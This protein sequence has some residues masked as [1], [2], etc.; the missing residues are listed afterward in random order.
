[1]LKIEGSVE[2]L[3]LIKQL[4]NNYNTK[5]INLY[6]FGKPGIGK[7]QI[8]QKIAD[9]YGYNI[10]NLRLSTL[11]VEDIIGIPLPNGSWIIPKNILKLNEKKSIL[12]L[13]EFNMGNSN[14]MPAIFNLIDRTEMINGFKLNNDVIIIAASNKPNQ[15]IYAKELAIP[16]RNRFV[17]IEYEPEISGFLNYLSNN[18]KYDK[19][20]YNRYTEIDK[21]VYENNLNLRQILIAYLNENKNMLHYE[22]NKYYNEIIDEI[23]SFPTPRSYEYSLILNEEY[24]FAIEDSLTMAVGNYAASNIIKYINSILEFKNVDDD[25]KNEKVR[26]IKNGDKIDIIKTM[27]YL[28]LLTMKLHNLDTNIKDQKILNITEN[29]FLNYPG[30]LI[31]YY[32]ELNNIYD[33]NFKHKYILKLMAKNADVAKKIGTIIKEFDISGINI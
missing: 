25:I 15:N 21:K 23:Y 26:I 10:L 30:E 24:K 8:L 14:I 6:I 22:D 29:I 27:H 12:F 13:D 4:I 1:M 7:T 32:I 31:S 9:E 33:N 20:S 5:P 11:N 28:A 18:F 19:I 16:L 2:L 3:K 17:Y